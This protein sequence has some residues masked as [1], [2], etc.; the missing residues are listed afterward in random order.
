MAKSKWISH[1]FIWI[2]RLPELLGLA[3]ERKFKP[4]KPKPN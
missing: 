1:I 3:P 2:S 4:K